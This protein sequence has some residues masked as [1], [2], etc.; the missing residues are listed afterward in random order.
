V[1]IARRAR[2]ALAAR[3]ALRAAH[4]ARR[5]AGPHGSLAQSRRADAQLG[6]LGPK[7]DPRVKQALA[8]GVTQTIAWA[9][10]TY[11]PAILAQPIAAELGIGRASVFGA[12]SVALV[13]MALGGPPVGRWIDRHGGRGMLAASN[14]VLAFGLGVLALT[15][16]T[17]ALYLAWCVLGVGM[18]MGLYDAAFA[19][20]VRLHQSEARMP[21]TGITL[22]AGFASTVGWPLTAFLAERFGWRETCLAW[23]LIHLAIALP[24]NLLFIPAVA[25]T[26]GRREGESEGKGAAQAAPRAFALIALFLAATSF[27]TSAMAAHLPG[28]LLAA[29]TGSVAAVAAA[30][31]LGPAQVVARVIEFGAARRF[32]VH[33]LLTARVATALHPVAALLLASAGGSALSATAFSVLHGGGN[34]L[35]TIVR[36]TL[37]LALFGPAGYGLR[38][39]LL[40]ILARG[41]QAAAP[42][43][44]AWVLDG[45]GVRSALALSGGL[46]LFALATLLAL[47]RGAS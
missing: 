15:H 20:L 25:T 13:V 27:V 3:P 24:A 18:A 44:F 29:G 40:A 9:S 12:F 23:A 36:G 22:I 39:G 32:S 16:S 46:S 21:I 37:P 34:G 43:S 1:E 11:L 2:C 30:S 42:F 26:A 5:G 6:G 7:I 4:G 19:A 14:L 8:I 10:S 31:L 47:R 33:P 41:M 45:Y 28:L 17:A 35:I 38:Q